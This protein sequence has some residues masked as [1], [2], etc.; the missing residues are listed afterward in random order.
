MKLPSSG[1]LPEELLIQ[2]A[3]SHDKSYRMRRA[4]KEA[5]TQLDRAG[6]KVPDSIKAQLRRLF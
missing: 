4:L 2:F 3:H 5:K 6:V 1:I